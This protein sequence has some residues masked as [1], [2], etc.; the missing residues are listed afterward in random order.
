MRTV[1]EWKKRGRPLPPP[2][3]VKQSVLKAYA[4]EYQLKLFVETG[5]CLGDMVEAMRESFD[6]IYSIE[7]SD[8]LF[9]EARLRFLSTKRIRIVHGDSGK[10][11]LNI[12]EEIRQPALF[13]LDAHYSGGIT[14]KGMKDTPIYDEL[15]AILGSRERGHVV[16]IDD[17]RCFGTEP[18]YPTL[19]ELTQFILSKRT[20]VEIAVR[21]DIIR[22]TPKS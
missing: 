19:E 6:D 18:A 13:W 21:D 11:L 12:V 3:A 7:L 2:F 1:R 4:K 22:V 20:G 14:A 8:R 5:T 15:E 16:V 17:A 10:E 9:T